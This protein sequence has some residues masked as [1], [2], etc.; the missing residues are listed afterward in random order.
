MN[1]GE[2]V[3]VVGEVAKAE[4][5]GDEMEGAGRKRQ[6]QGVDLDE[7]G[8]GAGM[9]E[10]G[11]GEHFGREVAAEKGF[12]LRWSMSE[13]SGRHIAGTAAEIKDVC[14]LVFE[15][16]TKGAGGSMPPE[17]IQAKGEQMVGSIVGRG[18]GVEHLLHVGGGVELGLRALG[19]G[20]GR[21][22]DHASRRF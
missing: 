22:R 13:Q 8:S 7:A 15:E 12:G 21:W 16:G 18:D 6:V 17:A 4:R 11:A 2:A 20:T 19:A 9:L 3:G 10:T 14:V 5:E 1:F